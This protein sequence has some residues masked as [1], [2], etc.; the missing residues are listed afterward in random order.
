MYLL[1]STLLTL[2]RRRCSQ[3]PDTGQVLHPPA[4]TFQPSQTDRIEKRKRKKQGNKG[5]KGKKEVKR[6]RGKKG[7][8]RNEPI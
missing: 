8:K 1:Y 4:E 7:K 2:S 6:A 3:A 5:K